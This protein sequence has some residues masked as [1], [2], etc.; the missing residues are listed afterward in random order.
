[1]NKKI[2]TAT[3]LFL[4]LFSFLSFQENE[5]AIALEE[6]SKQFSDGLD[7]LELAVEDLVFAAENLSESPAAKI[8]LQEAIVNTRLSYK[9]TEYLTAYFDPYNTKK[10]INGAPLPSVEPN[11]PE[12]VVIEPAGLQVLD[13][14]I[15]TDAPFAEKEAIGAL[16]KQFA[17]D[18]KTLR[19]YQSNISIEHRHV[20]E[21][22]R[23]QLV[24]IFTLGV[25]GFDTP[26]SV[27]PRR[28]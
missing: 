6:V 12:V 9:K 27:K 5:A 14:M 2:L 28:L 18:F 1:M 19:K 23:Q 10:N 20:F 17:M 26:G 24:R 21:A 16:A 25:T 3:I 8:A 11:V 15:F 7:E 13:E 4:S 22:M